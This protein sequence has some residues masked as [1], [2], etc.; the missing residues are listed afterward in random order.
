MTL[1]T[2]RTFAPERV[3][4]ERPRAETTP[5]VTEPANPFGLPIATTSWPTRRVS[6]LP[7]SAGTRSCVSVRNTAR[8]LKASEPITENSSS[9]PSTNDARPPPADCATM[10]IRIL[11]FCWYGRYTK[12]VGG[13]AMKRN[14]LFFATPTICAHG[15]SGSD[16]SRTRLPIAL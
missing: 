7:S 11:F 4:S 9:R 6:A 5:A 10:I 8:S 12:S 2:I 14:L 13:S 16:T 15:L 1:S 3:G